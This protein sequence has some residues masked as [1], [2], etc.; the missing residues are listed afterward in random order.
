[1]PVDTY[2]ES[3]DRLAQGDKWNGKSGPPIA[4][5]GLGADPNAT[6][7]KVSKI[8]KGS[9]ADK[10]GVRVNDIITQVDGRKIATFEDLQAEVV[11]HK[12]GDTIRMVIR[13][14]EDTL[15]VEAT[16]GKGSM[17]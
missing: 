15:T 14:G 12:P 9:A 6:D 13:R 4:R 10:A 1:V 7:C 3:W 11:K 17:D 5:L 16:L 8:D 2:R